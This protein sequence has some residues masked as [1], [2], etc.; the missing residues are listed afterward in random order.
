MGSTQ[1]RVQAMRRTLSGGVRTSPGTAGWVRRGRCGR[2]CTVAAVSIRRVG[3]RCQGA[4]PRVNAPEGP[5]E[6][7]PEYSESPSHP[8]R[9]HWL[10]E[11]EEVRD[12]RSGDVRS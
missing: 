12:C 5:L 1:L 10:D 6:S 4:G 2:L 11:V 3:M 9:G 8:S 7:A